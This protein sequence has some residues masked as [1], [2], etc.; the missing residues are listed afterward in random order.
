MNA[1]ADYMVNYLFAQSWQIALLAAI[2]GLISFALQ[3]RS[4]HIRYLLWLIVLAK[5]LVPPL[6]TVPLAVLPE[7][8]SSPSVAL[9][10][11]PQEH[12]TPEVPVLADGA[13]K[14]RESARAMPSTR[15]LIAA[16]WM[17]G[18]LIFLFWVGGRA[19]R[20]TAWL[21]ERRKPLPPVLQKSIQE[22]S[23]GF[24]FRRWPRIWLV[25]DISQPFVWG[26]LRGSVYLPADF[27]GLSGS[28][29]QRSILAHE[30][31]HI[32]RF[33]AGV[34]LL[35]VLV[36]AV[37][38]FHPLVWWANR[39]IR[40]EREKCCDETAVAHLNAPPEHYTEAIVDALAAERRSAHPIPSLA[41]VGSVRDIEERIKT[42]LRPGKRFYKRPSLIAASTVLLAAF[43][44]VPT[45]LV[46]TARAQ[47]EAPRPQ[48]RLTPPLHEAALAGD[49]EKVKALL[50]KGAN[51]NEKD[52]ERG[53]ALHCASEKGHA[54]V[55]GLLINRG[56]YVNAS[57]WNGMRPLHCAAAS[58]NKETV[59]LLLGK[60]AYLEAKE[61]YGRTPL[62]EAMRS[63]APGRKEMVE[64]L[65]ARGAKVPALH[66]AAYLA[67]IEKLKK[68]LQEGININS[69]A[70]DGG[71]ALHAA[72][73]SGKKDIVEF[74]IGKGANVDPKD[75]SAK[76]P[77]YYAAT[78]NCEEIMDLL[79]AKGADVN[80]KDESGFTLLYYAIWNESKDAVKL[81]MGK[82]ANVNARDNAY[83]HT[84]LD[85][86]IWQ[87]DKDIVELIIAGGADVNAEDKQG[88]TPLYLAAM[89]GR[90]DLVE[91]LT[92]KGAAPISA[93]HLAARVG[94]LAKVRSLIE[95]GANVDVRDKGGQTPLFPAVL[96]DNIDVAQFM[97]AKGADVNATDKTG[98]TALHG[99]AISGC[100]DA[101]ELL[102]AKGANVNA[103]DR[104]GKTPLH[105]VFHSRRMDLVELLIAKGA[106]V[107]ARITGGP[108]PKSIGVTPLHRAAGRDAEL[109]RLLLAKGAEINAQTS[110]GVTPLYI[111]C[112][113]GDKDVVTLLLAKG[114]DVNVKDSEGQ[115]AL[116][117]AKQQNH[118]EVA[119][120]LRKH[121]AKE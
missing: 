82:G 41:I 99:A 18:V 102:L 119:E 11:L 80:A 89:E 5:C 23:L 116:S 100:K 78:H 118:E 104:D 111:A 58:G 76:T 28:D 20:Y 57:S 95:A 117:L 85:F 3:N 88:N 34:N 25:E 101:V 15:E 114:A 81:L 54:E 121:G 19:I 115:T 37:Y 103:A 77:L 1:Y 17:A 32:A 42:M 50:S 24:K 64:L 60:G 73:D 91:L 69:Q 30:L 46:L 49:I 75:T 45:T 63:P 4:A 36:Q 105:L 55:A 107:N 83:G 53:T 90:Q 38:W 22:L 94:D 98:Q 29:R 67:D 109:V 92:A 2:V 61:R 97:I 110:E 40:Q 31:S 52:N 39:K 27:V 14:P 16:A 13:P 65:V 35:Q 12:S 26:M 106:D 74:L 48:T 10:D 84:P 93:I 6:L 66:L 87:H 68:S 71:T 8:S 44:T 21:R 96:T 62:F 120:L 47:T 56:A 79:L 86:A 108:F 59:E 112:Q 33:D 9:L 51:V 43:W 113:R 70:D 72:A 7:R